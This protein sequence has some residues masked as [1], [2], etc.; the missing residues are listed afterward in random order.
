L[1]DGTPRP[2]DLQPR[3]DTRQSRQRIPCTAAVGA[4]SR[5]AILGAS[6]W[7]CKKFNVELCPMSFL[8]LASP[9]GATAA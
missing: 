9:L 8:G 3:L 6:L 5:A 2:F 4:C 1:H 7:L